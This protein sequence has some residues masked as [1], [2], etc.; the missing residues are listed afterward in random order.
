MSES[1]EKRE[2]DLI[3]GDATSHSLEN[4]GPESNPDL[5]LGDRLSESFPIKDGGKSAHDNGNVKTEADI[6]LGDPSTYKIAILD[7]NIDLENCGAGRD[8]QT[9]FSSPWAGADH[10]GRQQKSPGKHPLQ[11]S[12]IR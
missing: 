8:L 5:A 7:E 2:V 10:L 11:F 9:N 12:D 1:H 3:L 4:A 6:A